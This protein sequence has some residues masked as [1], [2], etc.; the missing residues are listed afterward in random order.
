LSELL[1]K[2]FLS[3]CFKRKLYKTTS[4]VRWCIASAVLNEEHGHSPMSA[5]QR[6][7][8]AGRCFSEERVKLLKLRFRLGASL[9]RDNLKGKT[10]TLSENKK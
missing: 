1:N 6:T 4:G 3:G 2:L 9:K 5:K 7:V 10:Q 8:N